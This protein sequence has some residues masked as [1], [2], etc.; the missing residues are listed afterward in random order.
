LEANRAIEKE[1]QENDD[2]SGDN[3]AA[4]RVL[5]SFRRERRHRSRNGASKDGESSQVVI[6]VDNQ[7]AAAALAGSFGN[8]DEKRGDSSSL[9]TSVVASFT[10]RRRY[11]TGQVPRGLVNPGLVRFG[12]ELTCY[13]NAAIQCIA[14]CPRIVDRVLSR[15]AD[16]I[17]SGLLRSGLQ[18]LLREMDNGGGPISR[19]AI[20]FKAVSDQVLKKYGGDQGHR[21]HDAVDYFADLLGSVLSERDMS[22]LCTSATKQ[23]HCSECGAARDEDVELFSSLRIFAP[24]QGRLEVGDGVRRL[25]SGRDDVM[26]SVRC[27]EQECSCDTV[28]AHFGTIWLA[29]VLVIHLDRLKASKRGVYTKV[30]SE[31]L[32]PEKLTQEFIREISLNGTD[33]EFHLFATIHH[34]G[35]SGG[36]HYYACVK[37]GNRWFLVNDSNVQQINKEE[38]IGYSSTVNMYLYQKSEELNMSNGRDL[39]AKGLAHASSTEKVSVVDSQRHKGSER[40]GHDILRETMGNCD[41]EMNRGGKKKK[42]PLRSASRRESR[43]ER[44]SRRRNH[45]S[46]ERVNREEPDSDTFGSPRMTPLQL[47][48]EDNTIERY[49]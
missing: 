38:A 2:T 17:P 5:D 42:S 21:Q 37:Y 16:F 26:N 36:G 20:Q 32:G 44:R 14:C 48:R 13:S 25:F 12:D 15:D 46:S 11:N 39:V 9:V 49:V 43:R 33:T 18:S 31:C 28:R 23:L 45:H 47:N 35:G 30:K 40:D 29:D 19:A 3:D 7:V 1:R 27:N 41:D 4:A 6:A 10:L 34:T 8:S 22:I 24:H